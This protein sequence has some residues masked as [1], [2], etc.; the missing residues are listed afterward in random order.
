MLTYKDVEEA[1]G[2]KYKPGVAYVLAEV[3]STALAAKLA[4]G[5][6]DVGGITGDREAG[7]REVRIL[8]PPEK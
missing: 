8:E 5:Y 4:K 7:Q 1:L 2:K 3:K 6:K